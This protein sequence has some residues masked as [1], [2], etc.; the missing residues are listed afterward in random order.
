MF[1]ARVIPTRQEERPQAIQERRYTL[2]SLLH[3]WLV[4]LSV[5]GAVAEGLPPN[6]TGN[7]DQFKLA[8]PDL[9]IELVARE[10]LVESPC[11]F[12]FD[13]EGRLYVA[14]NRGYP[15]TSAPP[16]GRIA[17]LTDSDRD[18]Q[19]DR[20]TDFADG[21]T[22]PNGV[23]PWKGGV[24]VTCAPDVLFLR[25]IDGD[26]RAD[27]RRVLLTGFATTGST[28]LRVNA[29]T[30]GPDGWVYLAAGLSGG[31]I[32]APDH[33]KRAAFEMTADVKFHPD[34]LEI[35][36]V[37]GRSQYGMTFDD[38]GRRFICMNRLPVQQIVLESRWLRRNPHLAFSE[39]VQDCHDRDVKS[40]LRGGGD[41]VRLFPI[42][43]NVTTADSHAGSFSAACGVLTWPGGTLPDRYRGTVFSCDPTGNLVHVDRLEPNGAA[44]AAKP[45][46]PGKEFLASK[47]D[48]FRPV[49][50][51]SGPDGA[52]YVVDMYRK[53]IEHPDY[54]PEEVRKKTD[55]ESGKNMGRIYRVRGKGRPP[56]ALR[57][58]P[59]SA[60]S[61]PVGWQRQTSFRQLQENRVLPP[62][63][64]T[65]FAESSSEGKAAILWLL[66][67][68]GEL[69]SEELHAATNVGEARLRELA[70]HLWMSSTEARAWK[71]DPAVLGNEPDA[72]VR[73]TAALA[74][75]EIPE[76]G[77]ALAHIGVIDRND[78][79]TRAAVL[80]SVAGREIELLGHALEE[81]RQ[82][83]TDSGVLDLVTGL[84]RCFADL[85]AALAP[86]QPHR[87]L[88]AAKPAILAAL[89]TGVS[90]R[91]N[92]PLRFAADAWERR[93]LDAW[94]DDVS[95]H[96]PHE[97]AAVI[98]FLSRLRWSDAQSG[99]LRMVEQAREEGVRLAAI[100]GV[101]RFAESDVVKNLL[102]H[103]DWSRATPAVRES[104][105][106]ALFSRASHAPGLLTAIEAG[107]LPPSAIPAAKRNALLNHSDP[108][109]RQRAAALSL[110]T[111]G[112]RSEAHRRSKE[113]LTLKGDPGRGREKFSQL[114]A[115]CHRLD[116]LG[117][118][119][120]PDLLDIRNQTKENILF[121]VV[122]PDAEIAPAFGAYLVDTKDGRTLS[123][124]LTSETSSSLTLR[125]PLGVETNV[126]RS[127]IRSLSA[128]PNSLMPAGLEQALSVQ[129]LADLLAFLKGE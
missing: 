12:A 22:F 5:A 92:E 59:A 91:S 95:K 65:G 110:A 99:L 23:L 7:V 45:L 114:C 126:A 101:A 52:L 39:T 129:E 105:I 107:Q 46:F 72:R 102:Q 123:G 26:G 42:S 87:E 106:D 115:T 71:P 31:T 20:R 3:L 6:P 17:L 41:G 111:S 104:V 90:E 37:D 43:S 18:G 73:F 27:E 100:R 89:V 66:A 51:G 83:E 78:R 25:D 38:F 9:T 94:V 69:R 13:A 88:L 86:A 10:P 28:Q 103:L 121:H 76:G 85:G 79:W 82:V 33:P 21:L 108:D 64:I 34:T 116:R 49:F 57:A 40:G 54:L 56:A 113:A 128:L 35:Q 14:E 70:L 50:L 55:F 19:M 58:D 97:Q 60:L 127:E 109:V 93:A 63:L 75:G 77:A 84:G 125:G 62:S 44:F 74:L 120:G 36:H 48:W 119:V 112:D 117:Y 4:L 96:P 80:S 53:V 32:T 61:S 1:Y 118:A 2:G 24:I 47:D 8:D 29:P 11:A 122:V 81:L 30:L 124:I 15:N 67:S 68:R 98:R 16:V